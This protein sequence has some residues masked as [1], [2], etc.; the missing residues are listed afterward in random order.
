[1]LWSGHLHVRKHISI[2]E[3]FGRRN[4]WS[5]VLAAASM[6]LFFGSLAFPAYV[7]TE[8]P[9][10]QSHYGLEAVLLGPIGFFA[11]EFSWVANP[12]L[13]LSWAKRA[14]PGTSPAFLLAL[15]ALPAAVLF[16][17][18]ERIAVGSAGMYEYYATTGYYMWV[19]SMVVSAVAAYSYRT[20]P[21]P[22]A[23]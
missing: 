8:G 1:M 12:L 14:D 11:G 7:T 21:A 17:L 6:I 16:L 20:E 2:R 10:V 22:N 19:A 18:S 3:Y 9:N 13:W 4:A 15:L 23:F 5:N